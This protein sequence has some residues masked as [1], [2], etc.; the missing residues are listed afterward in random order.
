M[1]SLRETA[2]C[3]GISGNFSLLRDF[4]GYQTVNF[5]SKDESLRTQLQLMQGKHINLD[6]LLVGLESLNSA[7]TMD[8]IDSAISETR[9]IYEQ[10]RIGVGRVEYY[11]IS[12]QEAE[13]HDVI[14]LFA[15]ATTL[16]SKFRGEHDDAIDLFIVREYLRQVAGKIY[17]GQCW[18]I[19]CSKRQGCVMGMRTIDGPIGDLGGLMAHELGHALNLRHRYADRYRNN[20]MFI[21]RSGTELTEEQGRTM[22]HDCFARNGC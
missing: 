13:G 16:A 17:A 9:R 1:L 3:I 2:Q 7:N 4:F 18:I 5:S 22:R 6:I 21:N 12:R 19:R 15:E 11:P 10:V 14:T 20:L 8:V